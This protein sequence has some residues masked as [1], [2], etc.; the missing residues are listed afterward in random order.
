LSDQD[1]GRRINLLTRDE[2]RII[3]HNSFNL[4]KVLLDGDKGQIIVDRVILD[5]D[6]GQF[7][8]HNPLQEKG[9]E[10]LAEPEAVQ[11]TTA[12]IDSIP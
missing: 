12:F 5:G 9:I 8:I 6:K 10:L 2:C 1:F 3:M 4:Q 7:L 11:P